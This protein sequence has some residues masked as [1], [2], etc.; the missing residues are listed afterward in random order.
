[1]TAQIAWAA[2]GAGTALPRAPYAELRDTVLCRARCALP[3][4]FYYQG[5]PR[6]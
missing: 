1:M 6:W 2:P 4:W 5:L 3:L